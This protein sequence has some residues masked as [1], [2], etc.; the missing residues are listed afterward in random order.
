VLNKSKENP[1]EKFEL[2]KMRLDFYENMKADFDDEK[3]REDEKREFEEIKSM[4]E[5]IK[6]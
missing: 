1:T 6:Y 2:E 3:E 5:V 4:F